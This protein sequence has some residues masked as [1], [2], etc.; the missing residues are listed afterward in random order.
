VRRG[1]SRHL[2]LEADA[3]WIQIDAAPRT[4]IFRGILTGRGGLRGRFAPD[5][6]H[7]AWT[8]SLGGGVHAAGGFL[9]PEVGLMA[10]Y[11]NPW[12]TPWVRASTFLSQPLGARTVDLAPADAEAPTLDTPLATVGLRLG[13]GLAIGWVDLPLRLHLAAHVVHLARFD[14]PSDTVSHVG[15]GLEYRVRSTGPS[16][17]RP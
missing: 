16:S 14:G 17:S 2:E 12:L 11:E 13:A 9:A 3:G 4:P 8:A 6:P 15:L 10:G 7:L 5:L 1:L